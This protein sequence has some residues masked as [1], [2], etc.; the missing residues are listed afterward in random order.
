MKNLFFLVAFVIVGTYYNN[1]SNDLIPYTAQPV[2]P[3]TVPS[4]LQMGGRI[5]AEFIEKIRKIDAARSR[6]IYENPHSKTA[7]DTYKKYVELHH[8]KEHYE[9]YCNLIFKESS[10]NPNAKNP[11]TTAYGLGQFLDS[12]WKIVP[13]SKTSNPYDQLDAMFIYVDKVYGDSCKAWNFWL[14]KNWY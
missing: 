5:E 7:I 1:V 6:V 3:K 2:V 13:Q 11:K 8:S 4:F 14:E 9:C 12:T 10:W